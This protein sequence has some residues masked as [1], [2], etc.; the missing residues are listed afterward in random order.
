MKILRASPTGHL[1]GV[2]KVPHTP[3]IEQLCLFAELHD[4]FA[5]VE[6]RFV[7][8]NRT[9][10]SYELWSTHGYRTKSTHV[11]NVK[12]V[13]FAS[14]TIYEKKISFCFYPIMLDKNLTSTLPEVLLPLL[15]GATT[16][17]IKALN[18]EMETAFVK[19]IN[20]GVDLYKRMH[21]IA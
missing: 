9:N 19:L 11:K 1:K 7:V 5:D 12:D 13:L 20:D 10:N 16:F 15:Y 8:K 21:F 3:T 17:R 18:K 2:K 4:L 14:L 6:E